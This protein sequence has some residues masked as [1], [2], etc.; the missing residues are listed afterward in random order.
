MSADELIDA[1]QSAWA[2]RRREAFADC[3][4]LDVHYEDPLS[5]GPCQGL[6]ELGEHAARLWSV[7]SDVRVERSGERLTDGR[8]VAAPCRL[9]AFHDGSR[10]NLP[11]TKRRLA[12][13]VVL[14][15][16][17]DADGERLWRVRAF[18]D[19]FDAGVQLGLLPRPG[20]LRSRALLVLQGHGLRSR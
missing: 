13:Q 16:E 8:F 6:D 3:C 10:P 11:A 18:L 2:G 12:V 15:C 7:A 9:V 14:Y 17:L 4:A 19:A 1:F 5:E 20:S